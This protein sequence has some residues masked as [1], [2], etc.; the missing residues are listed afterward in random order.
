MSAASCPYVNLCMTISL[1]ECDLLC[2]VTSLYECDGQETEKREWIS[3][4]C[5]SGI[6]N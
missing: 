1:Y 6:N 3:P 5:V 2:M 4:D